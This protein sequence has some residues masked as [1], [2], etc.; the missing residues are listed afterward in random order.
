MKKKKETGL[1]LVFRSPEKPA[2][3]TLG[4]AEEIKEF[5]VKLDEL[6]QWFKDFKIDAIELWIQ[7]GIKGGKLT[8]LLISLEAKGGCKI[9]L[10]PK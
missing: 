9:T 5:K 2:L 1:V 4:A 6:V 10:R 8:E 7:T 3:R